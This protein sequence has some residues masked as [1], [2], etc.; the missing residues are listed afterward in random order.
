MK[1]L[2][3]L[4]LSIIAAGIVILLV[5]GFKGSDYSTY[6]TIE[7]AKGKPGKFVH[8]MAKVDTTKPIDYDAIKNP[9]YLS[10]FITDSIGG[11]ARVVY[12]NA[13]PAELKRSDKVVLKGSMNG[14]LFEC[15][16]IQLKCPSKYK[17][18]EKKVE[19]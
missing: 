1:P 16:E 10:F 13:M 12:K 7:S 8:V 19:P 9:N 11:S 6:E 4:F 2:H 14:D 15:S 17:D 3:I 5:F 18:E